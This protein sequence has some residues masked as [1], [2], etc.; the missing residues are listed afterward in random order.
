MIRIKKTMFR[1]TFATAA[2]ALVFSAFVHL[3]PVSAAEEV[4]LEK[5]DWSFSGIFGTYDRGALQRGYQVYQQVCAACHSI[6]LMSY[7]N[8]SQPGGPEFTKAQVKALAA[9]ADVQDGPN[10][11]GEMFDRPGRPSDRF[12]SPFPN[13]EAARAANEGAFPLDLSMIVKARRDGANYLY[14]LLTGYEEEAPDGIEVREGMNYNPY[15]TGGQIAMPPPLS[16]EAVEYSDGTKPT[17]ENMAKDVVTF[18][19]WVS[20]PKMEERKTLGFKVLIYLI[21][22][23][24][25]LYATTRKLW[26]GIKH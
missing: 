12:V 6:N 10:D 14:S 20:E 2:L 17:V 24:G 18:L 11:D 4:E 16:E 15:F 21:I 26:S 25:L 3:A 23:A 9:E 7:R 1:S 19:T 13:E 22:L 5:Q 8:L